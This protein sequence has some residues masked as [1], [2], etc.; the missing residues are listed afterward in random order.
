[1][2]AALETPVSDEDPAGG[3]SCG[4]DMDMTA[5][6]VPVMV[7]EV[8][9]FL[10]PA[11]G[12]VFLDTTLGGG[13]HGVA[14]LDAVQPSGVLIGC[15]RDMDAVEICRRR[16]AKYGTAAR[17]HHAHHSEMERV[18]R[19]EGYTSVDGVLFDLGLSSMQLDTPGRGFRMNAPEPLDMRMD[20]TQ[21]PTAADLIEYLSEGA[22]ADLIY[23]YGEERHSRAIA[24]AIGRARADGGVRRCDA[25]ASLIAAAA[26]KRSGRGGRRPR[27]HPATR[28]FQALRIAVNRE[29]ETLEDS[30]RGAV[31]L[32]RPGGRVVVISFHSLEDRIVKNL[33]RELAAGAAPTLEILTRRVVRPD[34]SEV[35]ENPRSRS[36]KLRAA[37]RLGDPG[38][39][40]TGR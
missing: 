24:R 10:A 29:V 9:R 7:Q 1:M 2:F 26:A 39:A 15:D 8:L 25:L 34:P 27:I 19:A 14:V 11:P 37:V 4:E 5:S 21:G 17:V 22:L 40:G 30:L 20:R 28:T 13:G 36:A 33:F 38:A 23:R 16:L 6:H 3:Y 32:L 18:V 31:D 35:R 12:A